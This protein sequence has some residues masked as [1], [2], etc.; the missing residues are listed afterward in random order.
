MSGSTRELHCQQYYIVIELIG[1]VPV[2][3][4]IEKY[5]CEHISY[6]QCI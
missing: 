6:I 4:S 1:M 5:E 2:I 3:C